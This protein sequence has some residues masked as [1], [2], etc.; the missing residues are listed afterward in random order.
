[1]A[2]TIMIGNQK[3]GIG[4]TTAAIELC[5][6]LGKKRRVL[7]IDMDGSRNFSK[8]AGAVVDGV[9]T[10]REAMLGECHIEEAIQHLPSFDILP[11]AKKLSDAAKEFTDIVDVKLLKMILA[12][13]QDKYDY[14]IIDN[15]P[16]RTQTMFMSYMA[17]DYCLALSE[18]DDNSF[19]G[20]REL[21]ADIKR[22]VGAGETEVKILGIVLNRSENTSVHRLA[23]DKLREIAADLGTRF[24][25]T[26]LR[27]GIA[28]TECKM[29]YSSINEYDPKCNLAE[30]YRN[31]AKEIIKAIGE[32]EKKRREKDKR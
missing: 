29:V 21:A 23:Y 24:F 17:S 30:D 26:T 32:E 8:C 18:G 28:A 25:K 31:L 27:K 19:T 5:Y 2:I 15:S 6:I 20:L 13:V 11:A 22:F 12:D 1:M 3:G 14:I 16:S 9:L 4:K 7:G 10:V